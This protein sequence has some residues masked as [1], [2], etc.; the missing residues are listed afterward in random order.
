VYIQQNT[1][2]AGGAFNI[3]IRGRNSL[4]TGSGGTVNGN[5]PLYIIDGIPFTSTSLNSTYLSS[6]NLYGGNPLSAINPSDI[7]SIEILKDADA[8]AIYGSRGANGVV[9]ITTKKAKAGKTK[10]DINVSRG[11]GQVS[12]K[13]KLLSTAQ[14]LEMR[15]EGLENDGYTSRLEDPQYD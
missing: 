4:R 2:V 3:Q 9:L 8:T 11:I 13:M 14:Y 15:M 5:L 1:G 7:E 10:F 6:S 12:N